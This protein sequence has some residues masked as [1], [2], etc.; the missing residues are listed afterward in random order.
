MPLFN[1]YTQAVDELHFET[2]HE[3]LDKLF[4]AYSLK[5]EGCICIKS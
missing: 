2:V 5:K 4:T 3:V 1:L